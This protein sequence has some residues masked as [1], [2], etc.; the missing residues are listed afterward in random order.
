MPVPQPATREMLLTQLTGAPYDPDA[1]SETWELF[2]DQ[3]TRGD[4]E[5]QHFLQKAVG[6]SLTGSTREE[7]L[8]FLYGPTA[9]GKS[10]FLQAVAHALGDY[11]ATVDIEAFLSHRFG[12]GGPSPELAKLRWTRMVISVEVDEGRKIAEG[13]IK[14][15]TG[16]D[17]I[18]VRGLYRDPE[19][20]RPTFKIWIAAN[21]RPR[22]SDTDDAIWRRIIVL[23][24]SAQVAPEH[25]DKSLKHRLTTTESPAVLAWGVRG[26]ILW[27]REGLGRPPAAVQAAIQSYQEE[28]DPIREWMKDCA[29]EAKPELW[30]LQADLYASYA[31]WAKRSGNRYVLNAS[32]FGQRLQSHGFPFTIVNGQRV[33][34]GILL[35]QE[36]KDQSF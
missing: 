25:R 9:T 1:R 4:K 22:V 16:G 8:F 2:L 5:L 27:Q 26:S 35:V 23:P 10:T 32:Q 12:G 21:N 20:F 29:R 3:S 14:L 30:T 6:Y 7:V 34:N 19:T 33:R 28:V 31:S 11:A 18:S 13:L 36:G 15:V 17:S 24:F